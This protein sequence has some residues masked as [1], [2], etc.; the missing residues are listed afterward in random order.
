VSAHL[1]LVRSIF[2]A[3]E[4]GGFRSVGWADPEMEYVQAEVTLWV[5]YFARDRALADLGLEE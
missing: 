2:A 1:D 4:R 5:T 3:H